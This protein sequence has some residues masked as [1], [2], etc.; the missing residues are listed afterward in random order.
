MYLYRALNEY[1]VDSLE[2]GKGLSAQSGKTAGFMNKIVQHIRSGSKQ[3]A[4]DCWISTCKDFDT[5]VCEYSLPQNGNYNTSR[6]RKSIAVID[7]SKWNEVD[8]KEDNYTVFLDAN[9]DKIAGLCMNDLPKPVNIKCGNCTRQINGKPLNRNLLSKYAETYRDDL[10]NSQNLIE[11]GAFDCSMSN[12]HCGTPSIQELGY[13]ELCADNDSERYQYEII[14][15]KASSIDCG[16]AKKATEVL[17]LSKIP[18]DMIKIVL[19]MLD[20]DVLYAITN[21]S[22]RNIVLDEMIN[23]KTKIYLN[24]NDSKIEV[25]RNNKFTSIDI[26]G[27]ES[28]MG[29]NCLI[30]LLDVSNDI[31]EKY[32]ELCNIKFDIIKQILRALSIMDRSIPEKDGIFVVDTSKQTGIRKIEKTIYYD[33]MVVKING[34]L[35]RGSDITE[36][37]IA[38][39]ITTK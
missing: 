21:E 23:K 25:T 3:N 7:L 14:P 24:L 11:Y 27:Y 18:Q 36:E 34:K 39:K 2:Q 17:F 8:R 19:S 13:Y 37:E 30:D 15:E 9:Q 20:I 6:T 31:E 10:K 4:E 12:D 38:S 22:E 26:K 5:C 33:M 1:D 16:I 29:S 28:L 35:L 32:D